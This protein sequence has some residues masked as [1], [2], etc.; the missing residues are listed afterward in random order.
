MLER[1][2]KFT[3][4]I[5]LSIYVVIY[6]FYIYPLRCIHTLQTKPWIMGLWDKLILG[7][8]RPNV[9]QT[10]GH[11]INVISYWYCYWFVHSPKHTAWV[12]FSRKNKFS[13]LIMLNVYAVDH[14]TQKKYLEQI[15]LKFSEL[16]TDKQGKTLIITCSNAFKQRINMEE[17]HIELDITTPT[18]NM[19]LKGTIDDYTTTQPSFIPR[20]RALHHLG[21]DVDGHE[22]N[23]PHEWM[24]D[25]N[26]IGKLTSGSINGEIIQDGNFWFDSYI[27]TNNNY[28]SPYIWFCTLTDDWLIY[29]VIWSNYEQRYAD[30]I[31][32]LAIVKD[33]KNNKV[34]HATYNS[35]LAPPSH[36]LNETLQ[37]QR[38][39]FE[40]GSKIGTEIFDDYSVSFKATNFEF[41]SKAIKGGSKRCLLYDYYNT[42]SDPSVQSLK[43]WDADYYK[44]IRNIQY[45]EYVN[46]V[47]VE[48][49]HNGD[50][51]TFV[52]RQIVDAKYAI[53]PS[54]PTT[55]LYR[56]P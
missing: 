50:T 45:A 34:L 44:T 49:T 22:T 23:S 21:V 29:I 13:D 20:Y 38:F 30:D 4:A 52:A 54:V 10:L 51:Q 48:I 9:L 8:T 7:A 6:A 35:K 2:I 46:D 15:P 32:R 5:L 17:D 41:K 56:T 31:T 47:N 39:H 16:R 36:M 28:L 11:P 24:S 1:I 18:I 55:I 26:T 33:R 43:G 25:N 40:S 12:L 27:G 42:D 3:I 53:D 14:S 37:P 19:T